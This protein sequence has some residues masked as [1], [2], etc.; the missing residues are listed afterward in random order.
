M[1]YTP[2]NMFLCTELPF[3]GRNDCICIKIF[4][5]INFLNRDLF[6]NVLTR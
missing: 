6:L 4:S 1:I 2:H 3:G 5:G